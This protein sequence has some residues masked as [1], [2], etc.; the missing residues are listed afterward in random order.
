MK[1]WL[2]FLLSIGVF[3]ISVVISMNINPNYGIFILVLGMVQAIYI[4]YNP[5]TKQETKN[6]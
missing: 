3:L 4:T 5:L 6:G 2:K 1:Y